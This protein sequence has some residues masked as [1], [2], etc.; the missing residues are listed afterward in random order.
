MIRGTNYEQR[1]CINLQSL[2]QARMP[3]LEIPLECTVE[4]EEE[5]D[6]DKKAQR[7]PFQ[8]FL[9]FKKTAARNV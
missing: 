2:P 5:E 7:N 1:S 9:F 8:N 4:D 6:D 3:T